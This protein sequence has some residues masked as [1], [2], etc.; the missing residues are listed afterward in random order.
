M[1]HAFT[2]VRRARAAFTM[3]EVMV[4]VAI[5]ALSLTALFASEVGAAKAAYR[6]RN[7]STAALL[8]RCK[9]GEIE[10]EAL[11]QGLPAIDAHDTDECC[12][13][14]EIDGFR[15]EWSIVR[16]VLPDATE[17]EES[18]DPLGLVSDDGDQDPGAGNATTA[19][20]DFLGGGGDVDALAQTAMSI[21]FPI[22][23]PTIEE[24]VRRAT[25]RIRWREGESE[26]GFDV[27]RY[28]VSPSQPT[29]QD[30]NA[31]PEDGS[32]EAT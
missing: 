30:P 28:L 11:I 20:G 23:K 17:D 6:A 26:R 13:G 19:V 14:A 10:E 12:E 8:A 15:C 24:Q 2:I 3:L 22:I 16:I 21:A 29:V 32:D 31:T 5:L 27:V 9:I 18:N 1:S 4:A 7:M 25:V